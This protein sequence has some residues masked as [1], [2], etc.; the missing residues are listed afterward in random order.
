MTTKE[1][2]VLWGVTPETVRRYCSSGRIEHCEKVKGIW[3]INP[4]CHKPFDRRFK[5][6]TIVISYVVE[7]IRFDNKGGMTVERFPPLVL[8]KNVRDGLV[9]VEE[10]KEEILQAA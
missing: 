7:E 6:P 8:P 10:V 1:A 5:K 4:L 2:A 3:S 9:V